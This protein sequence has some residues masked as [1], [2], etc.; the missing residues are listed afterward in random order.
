[1][2]QYA[3]D[4]IFTRL[5]V[6]DKKFSNSNKTAFHADA[7]M[8]RGQRLVDKRTERYKQLFPSNTGENEDDDN[9]I[10]NQYYDECYDMELEFSYL[11]L[12]SFS[13]R[14]S[15]I[16]WVITYPP[17]LA[18]IL[19]H[20]NH[21]Y[22]YGAIEIYPIF[23]RSLCLTIPHIT[24]L[25]FNA[26]TRLLSCDTYTTEQLYESLK[27]RSIA[28]ML[29]PKPFNETH[30]TS[31]SELVDYQFQSHDLL[32]ICGTH[33][34]ID[35]MTVWRYY[36]DGSDVILHAMLLHCDVSLGGL[37][38][39]GKSSF[40]RE[41]YPKNKDNQVKI[42]FGINEIKHFCLVDDTLSLEVIMPLLHQLYDPN[43]DTKVAIAD[44]IEWSF[45]IIHC[46]DVL[47]SRIPNFQVVESRIM[48]VLSKTVNDE[49]MIHI[50][51]CFC[52][53]K[54]HINDEKKKATYSN[55]LPILIDRGILDV[56]IFITAEI[57]LGVMD[58]V[59]GIRLMS[60]AKNL[61]EMLWEHQPCL[62]AWLTTDVEVA[63]KRIIKRGRGVELDADDI[64]KPYILQVNKV[65]YNIYRHLSHDFMVPIK[66]R[67]TGKATFNEYIID[68][69]F[70]RPTS[71]LLT[72]DVIY[73]PIQAIR[74]LLNF[75]KYESVSFFNN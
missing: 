26:A 60:V 75:V 45:L 4:T 54:R 20:N 40:I 37:I 32:Q 34:E 18:T 58:L 16:D 51:K 28:S 35:D 31:I 67:Q 2:D 29:R 13:T 71:R 48:S 46:V 52:A 38:G 9:E 69:T 1:L 43:M 70:F 74:Y 30:G 49:E 47:Y 22:G 41:R 66:H 33:H 59:K 15:N 5:A 17:T 56:V 63:E 24:S 27:A 25:Y 11:L 68:Y 7:V 50:Q 62:A 10:Y 12:C 65:L 44:E 73:T 14:Y 19:Q 8:E 64:V 39:A 53:I 6:S 42:A 23:R 72:H 21:V 55:N 61:A 36:G 57:C 3:T